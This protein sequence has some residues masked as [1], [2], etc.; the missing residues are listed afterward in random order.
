MNADTEGLRL[1]LASTNPGKLR[2]FRQAALPR[3]IAVEALPGIDRLPPCVED[4]ST[5]EENARKKAVYYSNHTDGLVF[6]DDSGLVVDA[7]GGAPGVL[8]ARFAGPGASDAANNAQLLDALRR[9]RQTRGRHSFKTASREDARTAAHYV[10]VIALARRARILTVT[11][12]RV[13]GIILDEARG[14]GGFGYDPY[15]FYPA[16][17]R[18]FA[19]LSA[20]EKFA[21]SHRGAAFRKLLSYLEHE[22]D[23][24]AP[25]CAENSPDRPRL[26]QPSTVAHAALRELEGQ[27]GRG[28]AAGASTAP[29]ISDGSP[30][31][32]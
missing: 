7:L 30:V 31:L 24:P 28:R 2:E 32:P 21:V 23:P 26:R 5:F 13:D 15:F 10:C 25:A 6:A 11:E 17:G 19:E 18:T 20:E 22:V 8:S 1:F 4:G 29:E 27:E 16:L 14:S 3:G 9:A 12:A